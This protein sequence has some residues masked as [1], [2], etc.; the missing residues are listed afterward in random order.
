[1]PG[2]RPRP[3]GVYEAR[4]TRLAGGAAYVV[5]DR[6][7]PAV[8]LRADPLGAAPAAGDSVLVGLLEGYPDRLAVIGPGAVVAPPLERI[9]I[10]ELD[11]GTWDT[12][13]GYH[14]TAVP[15]VARFGFLARV[16]VRTSIA[17]TW[18]LMLRTQPAG[19][20]DVVLEAPGIGKL[21]HELGWPVWWVNG[22]T[23]QTDTLY[24]GVANSSGA[25]STFTLT[26]L[27]GVRFA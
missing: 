10:T 11:L 27:E 23:P 7:D 6:L 14:W 26:R 3:G 12:G 17:T 2:A 8:E 18:S 15:G 4:V 9:L 16:Y 5:I 20:G 21:T 22:D 24:I 19:G 13:T 25:T 1:M